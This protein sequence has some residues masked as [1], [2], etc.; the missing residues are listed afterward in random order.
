VL[1]KLTNLTLLGVYDNQ[2]SDI[3][4]IG[5]LYNLTNL[6]LGMNQIIDIHPLSNLNNLVQ[7]RIMGNQVFDITPLSGLTM[8]SELSLCGNQIEDIS[9]LSNLKYLVELDLRYNP[10]K[11]WSPVAH[12]KDVVG[13]PTNETNSTD[14]NSI[15]EKFPDVPMYKNDESES[16]EKYKSESIN[17]PREMITNNNSLKLNIDLSH[18]DRIREDSQQIVN[19]LSTEEDYEED[20]LTELSEETEDEILYGEGVEGFIDS[21]TDTE[22]KL[23]QMILNQDSIKGI[24]DVEL[25]I[26]SINEKA[27]ECIGDNI[28]DGFSEHYKVYEE[29][30][31]EIQEVLQ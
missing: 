12:I 9:P 18:I 11:D 23:L 21:L 2:T 8:L 20:D 31:P 19:I 4:P 27:L 17:P 10:I 7:L 22:R 15:Y 1:G 29:Y 5:N 24:I 16:N 30:I 13:R 28:I 14:N 6:L 25:L 26:E 3:T